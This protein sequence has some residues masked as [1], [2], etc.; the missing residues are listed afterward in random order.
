MKDRGYE[1]LY[2]TDEVDEFA[3]QML[4]SYQDKE[5]KSV[6]SGDIDI[7]EQAEKSLGQTDEECKDL[8]KKMKD[9]LGDAVKEV[10]VS[11]RLKSHPVCLSSEG[12][13]SIE[14]EKILR[15]MPNGDGIKAN[16]ILELNPNHSIF[17]V[18]KAISPEDEEK[19]KTYTKLLY[20]QALLIEGLPIED[21][22]AFTNEICKLM[23]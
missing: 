3:L 1:I 4:A 18:L 15:Q 10:K 6:S 2:C 7:D 19:L 12:G 21:P 11:N 13:V 14:M 22:V 23:K 9:I 5:F 17:E 20:Q 8:F 16:K